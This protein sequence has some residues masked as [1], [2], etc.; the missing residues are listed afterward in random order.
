MKILLS[1][2][3]I[4]FFVVSEAQTI[5]VVNAKSGEPVEGVVL[6]SENFTTQTDLKGNVNISS[7][8]E[9][10]KITFSHPSYLTYTSTK[11]KISQ[12]G[13]KVLLTEDPIQLD[14]VVVS[15]NRWEQLKCG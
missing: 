6:Y 1:F 12:Q 7:F 14:E 9:Q 13:G 10:E 8:G 15:V 5:C 3:A 2:I 11:K 4:F